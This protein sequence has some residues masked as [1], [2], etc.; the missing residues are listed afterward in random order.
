V[1][2]VVVVVP[3]DGDEDEAEDVGEELGDERAE[4][5]ELDAVG[6][7]ELQHHDGDDDGDDAVAEGLE[8]VPGHG[9]GS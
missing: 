5:G 2:Q 8:P 6:R 7:P 4:V 1:E 3:V 9:A